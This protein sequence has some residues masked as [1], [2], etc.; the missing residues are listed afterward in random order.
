MKST[1]KSQENV[2]TFSK[3]CKE[4]KI[5]EE[6]IH[7]RTVADKRVKISVDKDDFESGGWNLISV[8]V[9]FALRE[10][11]IGLDVTIRTTTKDIEIIV[12]K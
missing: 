11:G 3:F 10:L 4:H 8:G 12:E 2:Q 1:K 9:M 7:W 5:A 6:S